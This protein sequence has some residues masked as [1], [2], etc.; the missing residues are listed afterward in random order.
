[1]PLPRS[2]VPVVVAIVALV[3]I[4][5]WMGLSRR[6]PAHAAI[7]PAGSPPTASAGVPVAL[8]PLPAPVALEPAPVAASVMTSAPHP[9]LPSAPRPAARPAASAKP[10]D[11]IPS[12]R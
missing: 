1:M 4:A 10:V 7:V 11:D 8:P 3:A 2:R 12:F 6:A 5:A 9:V